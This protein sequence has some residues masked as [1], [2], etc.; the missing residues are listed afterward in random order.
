MSA[1]LELDG[2]SCRYGRDEHPAVDNFSLNVEPGELVALLG[3]SGCGKTT[4]LKLICGLLQPDR[5][6]VQIDGAS[7]RGVPPERRGTAMVFQ[8]A[9]L[10]E[11]LTV[12][13]N[14]AFGLRMKHAAASEIA[15]RV[16]QALAQVQMASFAGRRPQELS[17]GEQQRVALARALVTDPRVLLLDEPFSALDASLRGEMR[18]LLLTIQRHD[19]HTTVF[20]THDQDEAVRL[21][22][23]IGLILA[24]RLAMHDAPE[25][26]Y[27][28]PAT[29]EAAAFF[30][31]MN[32]I[33]GDAAD[34]ILRT[35][36]GELGLSARLPP[37]RRCVVI[38]PEAIRLGDG[39]NAVDA[40]VLD[41]SYLGTRI[42]CRFE[43]GPQTLTGSL[44]PDAKLVPG[45]VVR[46]TLPGDALWPVD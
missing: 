27:R 26:F 3:P 8:T 28:R 19:P 15:P 16:Q 23:R 6:D 45:E 30:G 10:F 34:G 25:A 35:P 38:R 32:F 17:G 18:E 43:V 41:C 7:M 9:L 5:G 22:D 12:G 39:A 33:E 4:V 24:G 21:G 36:I 31:A 14:V 42:E 13:E 29:R 11:H 46:L 20:V 40:R 37:G 44:P 1:R 2:V